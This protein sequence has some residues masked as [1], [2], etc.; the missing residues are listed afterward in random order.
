MSIYED[1]LEA[2]KLINECYDIETGE[3][4]EEQEEQAK[5]LKAEILEQGMEALCKVRVNFKSEIEALKAE[6]KRIADKRKVLE[7]KTDRLE[8][9]I[10]DILHL[11]GQD[12]AKAG[13][14]TVGLR[15]SEAVKLADN[16]ENKD[17][18]TYEFKAD[19]KA[20]KDALKSGLKIEGAEMVCNLNLNV[21]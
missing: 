2:E 13:T 14:F 20:I 10:K 4:F 9:Y 19:K 6:E 1:V 16:F 3:I 21:R 12:K 5:A 11:S 7:R 18:G 8:E 15:M 17:F